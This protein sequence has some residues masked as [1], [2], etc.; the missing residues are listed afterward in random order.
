MYS[1]RFKINTT[2]AGT[3]LLLHLM[4]ILSLYFHRHERQIPIPASHQ[5][6]NPLMKTITI[7]V[8]RLPWF[9]FEEV[10]PAATPWVTIYQRARVLYRS[11]TTL[12]GC[13]L[14]MS[15]DCDILFPPSK[16]QELKQS[17]NSVV[18][19][20]QYFAAMGPESKARRGRTF[21]RL[22]DLFHLAQ[23]RSFQSPT[24]DSFVRSIRHPLHVCKGAVLSALTELS[25]YQ[26]LDFRKIF[27]PI[28]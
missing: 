12:D 3:R 18:T 7:Y 6:I 19:I 28:I 22:P 10:V 17:M 16:R 5:S 9:P 26:D 1:Q 21:H 2:L 25:L 13:G 20:Y 11:G 8:A 24:I 15:F 27:F 4:E 23:H 14:A